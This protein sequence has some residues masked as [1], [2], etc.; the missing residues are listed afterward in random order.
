MTRVGSDHV[1]GASEVYQK[2]KKLPDLFWNRFV[3]RPIAAVLVKIV[4]DSRVT[5]NQITLASFAVG[6]AS[7]GL[8]IAL[9]GHLGLVVAEQHRRRDELKE[10]RERERA[11]Q[12]RASSPALQQL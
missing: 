6:V 12:H 3:C 8:I 2:T 1:M 5:P 11:L 9:P 10:S 7:A 4:K